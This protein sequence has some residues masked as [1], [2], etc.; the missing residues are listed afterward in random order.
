ME[1]E[2]RGRDEEELRGAV[3]NVAWDGR[4]SDRGSSKRSSQ[5][6]STSRMKRMRTALSQDLKR[7]R[8]LK[9]APLLHLQTLW[10]PY[11]VSLTS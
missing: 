3:E 1:R 4:E 7:A 11:L 6:L 2:M 10:G 8:P 9:V 5:R